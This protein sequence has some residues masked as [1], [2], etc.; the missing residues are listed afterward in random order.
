MSPY[1]SEDPWSRSASLS[2]YLNRGP[3]THHGT[4]WASK[5]SSTTENEQILGASDSDV[6]K[7]AMQP[8]LAT[9]EP[10]NAGMD[11]KDGV[12]ELSVSDMKFIRDS[13]VV[14]NTF[15]EVR[16]AKDLLRRV[17]SARCL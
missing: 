11:S 9:L 17:Q 4:C 7:G 15:L 12:F 2:P 3:W 8:S 13:M 6:T 10:V 1:L 16:P 14:V 5:V